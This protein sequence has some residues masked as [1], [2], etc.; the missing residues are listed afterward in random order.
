VL[1]RGRVGYFRVIRGGMSI[2]VVVR[3]VGFFIVGGRRSDI[4][5]CER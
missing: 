1:S 4:L 2:C 3:I 5:V